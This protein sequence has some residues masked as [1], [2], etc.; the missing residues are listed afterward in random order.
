MGERNRIL[1]RFGKVELSTKNRSTIAHII[2]EEGEY[3]DE[4]FDDISLLSVPAV[5]HCA[6]L[7]MI[8]VFDDPNAPLIDI[9]ALLSWRLNFNVTAKAFF[10]EEK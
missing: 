5:H 7:E 9:S 10:W 2:V 8:G 4:S 6:N 1:R 3:W